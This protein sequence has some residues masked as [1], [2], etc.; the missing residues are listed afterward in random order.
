MAVELSFTT[1]A[2]ASFTHRISSSL[3]PERLVAPETSREYWVLTLLVPRPL[4][5]RGWNHFRSGAGD[6]SPSFSG[7]S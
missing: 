7:R 4:E 6:S 3:S 5:G 2:L 1:A